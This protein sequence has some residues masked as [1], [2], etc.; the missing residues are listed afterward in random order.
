MYIN[1]YEKLFINIKI[2]VEK[3]IKYKSKNMHEKGEMNE[4][5]IGRRSRVY[6]F[7]YSG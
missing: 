3:S 2:V 4:D 1:I 6:W 7:T 5:F